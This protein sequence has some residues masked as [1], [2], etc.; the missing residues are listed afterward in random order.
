M[1]TENRLLREALCRMLT[2]NGDIEVVAGLPEKSLGAEDRHAEPGEVLLLPSNG[3]LEEHPE[4]IGGSAS[5]RPGALILLIDVTGD[6]ANF[7]QC[8]RAEVRGYLPHEA[9]AEEVV[10]TVRAIHAG[11]AGQALRG[12][13]PLSAARGHPLPLRERATRREQQII[14]LRRR[15]FFCLTYELISTKSLLCAPNTTRLRLKNSK[16]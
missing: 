14:P 6:E 4:A 10:E 2:R 12:V 8:V 13:I 5:L 3:R 9:S 11:N 16:S 1:A 7:L 15:V